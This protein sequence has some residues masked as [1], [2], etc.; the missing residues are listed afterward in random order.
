MAPEKTPQPPLPAS[1]SYFAVDMMTG[2]CRDAARL[3]TQYQVVRLNTQA[4][5]A[6]SV[7]LQRQVLAVGYESEK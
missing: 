7:V 4:T 2:Y 3:C 5:L 1:L 6:R